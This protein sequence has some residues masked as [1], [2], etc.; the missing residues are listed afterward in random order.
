M[1]KPMPLEEECLGDIRTVIAGSQFCDADAEIGDNL[2]LEREPDNPHDG[3][4]I[5]I[6]NEDFEKV[7]YVPRKI[8]SWLAPVMDAGQVLADA[9]A[10]ARHD[11]G[12]CP[13]RLKLFLCHKGADI[14][15][16]V[17]D[18][19]DERHAIH[20]TVL[21]T[22]VA[23]EDW[24]RQDVVAG[25]GSRLEALFKRDL[26][27]ETKMLL[28][29][30]PHRAE[31]VVKKQCEATLNAARLFISSL[32]IRTAIR[33]KNLT[34]CPIYSPNGHTPSYDLLKE[35]I[36]ASHAEV[37]EMSE[38]GVVS[39]L[40]I[41]NRGTRRILIPEGIMLT[42]AKQDRIVNVTVL[43]AAA[44]TFTLPVSCVEEGRW[45]SVS[46]GFK[47]THYA[48]HSL[49]ANNNVSV[50]EDR[51]SGG[52][53]HGDQNQVWN[54][55]ARTMSDMH[56]ESETQS[57]PESYEKASDLMAAYGNSISLP[58]GCSGVLVGIAGRICGMD[59]FGHADTFTRMWP[60]LSDAY[61]F[62]AARQATDESVIP[63]R[64]ASDYLDTVRETL[65]TSHSTLGEGTELHLSDPRIT[66]SALW[67]MDR[68]C[69]L[70]AS[71]VPEDAP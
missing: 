5:R 30:F 45:S 49:R 65:N 36:E 62:E 26:L 60:G 50:R 39:E 1:T 63:D 32:E 21:E 13:V 16:L 17:S 38:D 18:P 31:A 11:D 14:L 42:G 23:S 33:H 61:F 34:I 59:Y 52:R 29:L 4:A 2:N 51:E 20:R 10:E 58:E 70:T 55:V 48:P 37:T 8:A 9:D 24:T 53:G 41:I 66:G 7:G 28:A 69:H 3:H 35:A 40:Q 12:Q 43:V 27:P 15:D 54:D 57:L 6:E 56:V 19:I 46:H 64:Q 22:F 44:S 68:L 71:T 47:A 67:D 25:V